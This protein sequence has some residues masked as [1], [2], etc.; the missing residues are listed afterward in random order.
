MTGDVYEG[1]WM[2]D[3][4]YGFGVYQSKDGGVYQGEWLND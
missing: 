3:K 4:A 2:R 1:Q